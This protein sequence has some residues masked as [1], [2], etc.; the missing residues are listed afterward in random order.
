LP[1]PGLQIIGDQPRLLTVSGDLVRPKCPLRAVGRSCN[2]NSSTSDAAS[3][4]D[5]SSQPCPK[6]YIR[7]S[8]QCI[9]WYLYA[10]TVAKHGYEYDKNCQYVWINTSLFTS[11]TLLWCLKFCNEYMQTSGQR[12]TRS[13]EKCY[14]IS[15]NMWLSTKPNIQT[16]SAIFCSITIAILSIDKTPDQKRCLITLLTLKYAN[17][18]IYYESKFYLKVHFT[19]CWIHGWQSSWIRINVCGVNFNFVTVA[20]M[21]VC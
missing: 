14:L 18:Q 7:R 16:N 20:L 2:S 13:W 17:H 21:S 10:I 1:A 9:G 8:G 4:S 12:Q 11:W 6:G 3:S 19:P 5:S 15:L